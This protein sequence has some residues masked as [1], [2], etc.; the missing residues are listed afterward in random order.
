MQDETAHKTSAKHKYVIF[1]G[2]TKVPKALVDYSQ[3]ESK[4]TN[5]TKHEQKEAKNLTSFALYD[6]KTTFMPTKMSILDPQV[7]MAL[8]PYLKGE[9][10][11]GLTS[12]F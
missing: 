1:V 9:F 11:S 4:A 5:A 7:S 10:W 12:W 6:T 3:L 2:Y 8:F